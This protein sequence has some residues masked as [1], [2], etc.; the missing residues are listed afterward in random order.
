MPRSRST[1]RI[2]RPCRQY[3]EGV[4]GP[5][6]APVQKRSGPGSLVGGKGNAV[7][8]QNRKRVKH[9]PTRTKVLSQAESGAS[10]AS[11]SE[12]E[13]MRR[14]Q[15]R[16]SK[17]VPPVADKPPSVHSE[18]ETEVVRKRRTEIVRRAQKATG[19][20]AEDVAINLAVQAAANPVGD[21][22]GGD[23]EK[24]RVLVNTAV[25]TLEQIKPEGALQ[26]MLA[27][28]MIGVHNTA[29]KFLMRATDKDQSFEGTDANVQRATR[30]M[31]LFNDQLQAYA[32][33]KGKTS[34][35]RV[36]VEHVHVY[37]GGQ[38]IVGS[39]G[40]PPREGNGN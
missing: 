2:I 16:F 4:E 6:P 28:Q 20:S 24:A 26:S 35:Q 33:L 29:I 11:L 27:V 23:P 22:V 18:P 32:K 1:T 34:E 19:V 9:K 39:V 30:L 40:T 13:L 17:A 14:L 36:T 7:T 3:R 38:A 5:E 25:E 31:R 8:V 15:K 12:Q 21:Y 37:E 10:L